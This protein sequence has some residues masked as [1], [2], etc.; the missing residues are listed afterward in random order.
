MK[1]FGQGL[2]VKAIFIVTANTVKA[3]V[4]K[5]NVNTSAGFDF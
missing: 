4:L 3:Y 1:A 2:G 5:L